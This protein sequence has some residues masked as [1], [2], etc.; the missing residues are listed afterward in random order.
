MEGDGTRLFALPFKPVL[1]NL[2]QGWK[3][4]VKATHFVIA[5]HDYFTAKASR[6][7]AITHTGNTNTPA[8]TVNNTDTTLP[9]DTPTK[10]SWALEYINVRLIQPLMEAIDDDASSFVTVSELNNFTSSRPE[11]WRQVLTMTI[12]SSSLTYESVFRA[13][14][15]TGRSVLRWRLT[16]IGDGSKRT[17]FLFSRPF[18]RFFLQ[19]AP[20]SVYT[21]AG[22]LKVFSLACEGVTSGKQPTGITTN[23]SP[24]SKTTFWTRK[25]SSRQFCA[26]LL[27]TSTK[28]IL[29]SH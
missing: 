11:G 20:P 26:S 7:T 15:H 25:G 24:G 1:H 4:G 5:L 14:S 22:R 2:L 6:K 10:D 9:P 21:L 8:E 3:G 12:H 17:C 27:T 29:S 18:G 13:G 23:F 16:G 19:T 28:I